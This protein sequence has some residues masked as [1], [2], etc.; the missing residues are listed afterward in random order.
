MV[1][2]EKKKINT[3]VGSNGENE[4]QKRIKNIN[5]KRVSKSLLISNFLKCKWIKITNQEA[6]I[7]EV[8][9][10]LDPTIYCL[11]E[12]HFV[13]KKYKWIESERMEKYYPLQIV[14]K[15]SWVAI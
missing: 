2:H 8:V 6:E 13:S 3:K 14:T 11:Q 12:T 4:G 1:P 9:K 5:S 10:K 15:S 7:D